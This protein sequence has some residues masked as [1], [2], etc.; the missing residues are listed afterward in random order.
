MKINEKMMRGSASTSLVASTPRPSTRKGKRGVDKNKKWENKHQGGDEQ[1][2][3]HQRS[4]G[5]VA[6]SVGSI[7]RRKS[8]AT[9]SAMA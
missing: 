8:E 1:A 9:I 7:R 3:N 5:G 4:K 2:K 6:A